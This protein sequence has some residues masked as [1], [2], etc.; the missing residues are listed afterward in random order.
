ML[1]H[2]LCPIPPV[3]LTFS[4]ELIATLLAMSQG[5]VLIELVYGEALNTLLVSPLGVAGCGLLPDV[6]RA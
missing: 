4:A 6:R 5:A 2:L 1:S 3:L